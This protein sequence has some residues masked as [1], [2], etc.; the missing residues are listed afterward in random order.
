MGSYG[1]LLDQSREAVLKT[2]AD[3]IENYHERK[4]TLDR[5]QPKAARDHAPQEGDF[6]YD[7]LR[8][9]VQY[10]N[11][12]AR[13]GSNYSIIASR[14]LEKLYGYC[15]PNEQPARQ[16]SRTGATGDLDVT[17]PN[18]IEGRAGHSIARTIVVTNKT[19]HRMRFRVS[20]SECFVREGDDGSVDSKRSVE[21]VT[22]QE[23][24]MTLSCE[25]CELDS[26]TTLTA[27][28]GEKVDVHLAVTPTA[29]MNASQP[30]AGSIDLTDTT[31]K[32]LGVLLLRISRVMR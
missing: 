32:L 3:A 5:A 31:G 20:P 7:F 6:L 18:V 24:A 13:L 14:A 29:R 9:N 4:S 1:D 27:G 2:L 23:L 21:V 8:L 11:Q 26:N 10:L 25:H 16:S 30:Y 17:G 15:V 28:P 22:P 12:F 19:K